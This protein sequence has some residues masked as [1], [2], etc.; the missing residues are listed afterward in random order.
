MIGRFIAAC[1]EDAMTLR[2]ISNTAAL[3]RFMGVSTEDLL[4]SYLEL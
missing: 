1:E 3:G 2:T 4:A